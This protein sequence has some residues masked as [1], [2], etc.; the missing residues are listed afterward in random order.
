MV[1]QFGSLC[2]LLSGAVVLFVP[3]QQLGT[4]QNILVIK[5]LYG[6]GRGVF[7]GSCRAVYAEL[8]VGPDLSTAFSA[9]TL[10]AGFSGGICYFI[11]GALSRDA[12]ALITVVNGIFAIILYGMLLTLDYNR[13]QSWGDLYRSLT[14]CMGSR[15]RYTEVGSINEVKETTSLK[16]SLITGNSRYS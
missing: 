5:G 7:E 15:V 12:I 9:Q 8:F 14:R 1:I 11:Y 16:T 4:W 10:L 13:P 3:D 6:L 2:F